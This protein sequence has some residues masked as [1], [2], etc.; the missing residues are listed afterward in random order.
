MISLDAFDEQTLVVKGNS[1]VFLKID[2]T[3][4]ESGRQK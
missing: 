1:Q 2:G 3:S 4:I